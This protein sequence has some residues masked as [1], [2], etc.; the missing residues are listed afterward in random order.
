MKTRLLSI[1]AVSAAVV[2]L[3][4]ACGGDDDASADGGKVELRFQSLA[5]QKASIAA[6]EDIV[7]KWNDEHPDIQV[8]YDGAEWDSVHDK[9]LTAFEGGD[10]P[11]VIHY[12]A[13]AGQVFA[14]GGYFADL[15]P[16]LSDDFKAGIDDAV[17]ETVQ[18]DEHGTVGIDD[19]GEHS[20]RVREHD[21]LDPS[22]EPFGT[23]VAD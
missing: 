14:E 10:P 5:W 22:V 19:T 2:G 12:E 4:S 20:R 18:Y 7:A 3:T 17:W 6:N 16:L 1:V 13:S 8:T 23:V 21:V 9:L 15:E 11:D